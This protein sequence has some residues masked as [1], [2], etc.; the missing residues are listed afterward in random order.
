MT[1]VA[2]EPI[3]AR[4]HWSEELREMNACPDAV[5]WAERIADKKT[6]WETCTRGDWMLWYVAK[7]GVKREDL[8]L[9]LCACSRLVLPFADEDKAAVAIALAE[10]WAHGD[11]S[12]HAE[13]VEHATPW[14]VTTMVTR[15]S[16]PATWAA[17][18]CA[19][20]VCRI[21]LERDDEEVVSLAPRVAL[22]E[23]IG[24]GTMAMNDARF[25]DRAWT[26]RD[27]AECRTLRQCAEIVRLF[28]E[29]A[30]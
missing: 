30:P 14:E 27:E 29:V 28:W 13:D 22:Q 1:F 26:A 8:I 17:E 2:E 23:A 10:Q 4:Y 3:W 15:S 6:A 9:A 7:K 16:S 5:A 19:L 18:E 21:I 20:A 24:F 12:V 25:S 11:P